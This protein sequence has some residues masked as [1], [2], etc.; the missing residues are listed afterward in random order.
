MTIRGTED[1]LLINERVG[2][3]VPRVERMI[4]EPESPVGGAV[5][6]GVIGISEGA[7]VLV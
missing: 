4:E 7:I 2:R 6:R 1:L 5:E 3:G